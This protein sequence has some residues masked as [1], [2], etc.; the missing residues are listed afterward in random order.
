MMQEWIGLVTGQARWS[1]FSM[2]HAL[3]IT[4]NTINTIPFHHP[5]F[6]FCAFLPIKSYLIT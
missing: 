4:F 3:S 6:P 1:P 5:T 2:Y